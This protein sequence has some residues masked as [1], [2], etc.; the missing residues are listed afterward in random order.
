MDADDYIFFIERKPRCLACGGDLK[1]YRSMPV[2]SDGS[3]LRYVVCLGCS[4]KW[5]LVVEPERFHAVENA[6]PN[7][8][9][10]SA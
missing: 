9:E 7:P 8:G 6:N 10:S 1:A 4:K 2:E 3:R 5:R